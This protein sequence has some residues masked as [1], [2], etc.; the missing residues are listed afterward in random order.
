MIAEEIGVIDEK[1]V[2]T[3]QLMVWAHAIRLRDPPPMHAQTPHSVYKNNVGNVHGLVV[4]LEGV[5]AR[6]GE[7]VFAF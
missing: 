6:G 1:N 4:E 7:K 5:R 2:R 3:C